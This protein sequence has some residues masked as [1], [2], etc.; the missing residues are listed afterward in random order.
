MLGLSMVTDLPK[1][2]LRASGAAVGAAAASMSGSILN[3]EVRLF[4]RMLAF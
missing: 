4:D 2:L 3:K 1:S